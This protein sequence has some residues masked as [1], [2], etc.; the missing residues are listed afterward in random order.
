M[1]SCLN[2][3]GFRP[4][5]LNFKE[6]RGLTSS[7]SSLHALVHL[8]FRPEA[9][10]L[11]VFRLPLVIQAYKSHIKNQYK[12]KEDRSAGSRNKCLRDITQVKPTKTGYQEIEASKAKNMLNPVDL[13]QPPATF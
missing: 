3:E 1:G 6:V 11:V 13:I 2:S 7:V 10:K 12:T 4:R 5:P 9:L 8:R